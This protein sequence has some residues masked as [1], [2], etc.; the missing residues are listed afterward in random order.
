MVNHGNRIQNSYNSSTTVL[1]ANG[2]WPPAANFTL[3]SEVSTAHW[4]LNV[5]REFWIQKGNHY[6]NIF[7]KKK[8]EIYWHFSCNIALWG[9]HC[10]DRLMS[11]NYFVDLCIQ[12]DYVHLKIIHYHSFVYFRFF[13]IYLSF[14]LRTIM[15]HRSTVEVAA[16][17]L[18]PVYHFH[19]L[20]RHLGISRV[21]P[22]ESWTL[23]IGSS[24]AQNSQASDPHLK[25][26]LK[27][28]D[29]LWHPLPLCDRRI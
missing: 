24:W 23:H 13:F 25:H 12:I 5:F 21:I 2:G 6:S 20:H 26:L 22:T 29:I 8:C 16:T 28:D 4:S 27:L 10:D 18:T 14:L 19:M 15:I 3:V 7:H 17:S 1:A 9:R 11:K